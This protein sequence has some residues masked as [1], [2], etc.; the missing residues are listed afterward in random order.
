MGQFYKTH[1]KGYELDPNW[2]MSDEELRREKKIIDRL[3]IERGEHRITREQL[4]RQ[5]WGFLHMV[6]TTAPDNISPELRE[7][8]NAFI[9]LFGKVYPCKLCANYFMR[10]LKKMGEFKGNT[11][12]E[13]MDYMC[14]LHNRVNKRLKKPQYDCDMV[15]AEWGTCDCFSS[16]PINN[17]KWY[18]SCTISLL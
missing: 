1:V 9:Y 14:Q 16:N 8:I 17:I 3:L 5:S 18:N 7:Q 6:S 11:R 10:T 12:M 13:F 4:G 2:Q 15:P